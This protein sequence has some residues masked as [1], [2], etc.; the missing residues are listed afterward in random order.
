MQFK[1]LTDKHD[2][3]KP[4]KGK[5]VAH[6][7]VWA[8]NKISDKENMMKQSQIQDYFLPPNVGKVP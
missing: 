6:I 5:L 8:N 4:Q 1:Q 2:A 3:R 7:R